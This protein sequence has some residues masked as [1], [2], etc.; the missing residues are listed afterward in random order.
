MLPRESIEVSRARR[1]PELH[2][3]CRRSRLPEVYLQTRHF[4]GYSRNRGSSRAQVCTCNPAR[5]VA[6]Q[7]PSDTRHA[8][9]HHHNSRPRHHGCSVPTRGHE[10]YRSPTSTV[11]YRY[12]FAETCLS[13]GAAPTRVR[14]PD[15]AHHT[16]VLH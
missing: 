8:S 4:G 16:A 3:P 13:G 2:G 14:P 11:P 12:V 1:P 9:G 7:W 15:S 6:V 5:A 10:H